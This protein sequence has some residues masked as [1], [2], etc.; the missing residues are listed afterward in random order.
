MSD[1]GEAGSDE[2]LQFQVDGL[3]SSS[4]DFAKTSHAYSRAVCISF[5]FDQG[6][7]APF[8]NF[9]S[10]VQHLV[11]DF[12]ADNGGNND[13]GIALLPLA[14]HLVKHGFQAVVAAPPK[15]ST[16]APLSTRSINAPFLVVTRANADDVHGDVAM[17]SPDQIRDKNKTFEAA[18]PELVIVDAALR[19]HL[20]LAPATAAYQRALAAAVP[21]VFVGTYD[22]LIRLVGSL[23]PAI[24]A[25][26]TAQGME[27]PPWRS[28]AALLHRWSSV[29]EQER[30]LRVQWPPREQEASQAPSVKDLHEEGA[31]V[32]VPWPDGMPEMVITADAARFA[33]MNVVPIVGFAVGSVAVGEE[34]WRDTQP[35]AFSESFLRRTSLAESDFSSVDSGEVIAGLSP[36]SVFRDA[37]PAIVAEPTTKVVMGFV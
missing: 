26:F 35:G 25:N 31:V 34:P 22:R 4:A 16:A 27:R 24:A 23:C 30:R 8:G 5:T 19:E 20:A 15:P 28:K 12:I 21:E 3:D 37:L 10:K 9:E 29:E 18:N 1:L 6:K 11:E 2:D 13:Q 14:A 17:E 33:A 32:E 7:A 36:V